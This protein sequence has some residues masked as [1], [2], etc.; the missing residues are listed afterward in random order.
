TTGSGHYWA[1]KANSQCDAIATPESTGLVPCLATD[2]FDPIYGCYAPNPPVITV[3]DGFIKL[4]TS[5]APPSGAHC[6]ESAD[7]GRMVA[8]TVNGIL[9]ICTAIGW[10]PIRTDVD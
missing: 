2:A 5:S 7:E 9:Y 1:V 10:E 3:E 4:D 8:D 6:D